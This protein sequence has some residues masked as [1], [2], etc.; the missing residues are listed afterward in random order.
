[1]S[2]KSRGR[3]RPKGSLN[4]K[5]RKSKA[6]MR[7]ELAPGTLARLLQYN[8]APTFG[9]SNIIHLLKKLHASFM[10]SFPLDKK[11]ENIPDIEQCFV[12]SS[13][14]GTLIY[15]EKLNECQ[16]FPDI[17]FNTELIKAHCF[18]YDDLLS[19]GQFINKHQ[20]I[21]IDRKREQEENVKKIPNNRKITRRR[22]SNQ[23]K[24]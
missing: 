24:D 22:R 23:M 21:L 4:K 18:S 20:Q 1:M 16:L 12:Q 19:L 14:D 17:E 11:V 15:A 10:T 2:T 8:G 7:K 3:G 13:N 9:G 6:K 5:G